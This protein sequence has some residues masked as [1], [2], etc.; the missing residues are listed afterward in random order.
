MFEVRQPNHA[1]AAV[2]RALSMAGLKLLEAEH[3]LSARRRMR[4]SRAA[5]AA[6]PDD[7]HIE[8]RH[9]RGRM[10]HACCS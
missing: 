4:G 1:R 3:A 9:A 6:K 8:C 7:D 5:H 10:P 2:A